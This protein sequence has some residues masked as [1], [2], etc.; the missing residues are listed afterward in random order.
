MQIY[1]ANVV[2]MYIYTYFTNYSDSVSLPLY[3]VDS[4]ITYT[5]HCSTTQQYLPSSVA[6]GEIVNAFTIV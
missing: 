4:F 1:L 3:R 5:N 2:H 6:V